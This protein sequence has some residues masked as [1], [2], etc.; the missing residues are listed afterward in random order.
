MIML[1]HDV[2]GHQIRRELDA[3]IFKCSTAKA[4]AAASFCRAPDAFRSTWPPAKR[5]QD[6]IDDVLLAN[7]DFPIS[8]R[9]RLSCDVAS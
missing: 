4:C 5:D 2:G 7:N 3:R 1:P 6:A 8:S 9:T